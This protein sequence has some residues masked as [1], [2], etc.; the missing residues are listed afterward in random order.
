MSIF[1]GIASITTNL[2]AAVPLLIILLA[3]GK[4]IIK[5]IYKSK[6]L[7]IGVLIPAILALIK[8][9][10]I[11]SEYIFTWRSQ[12]ANLLESLG[13]SLNYLIISWICGPSFI[14]IDPYFV[15]TSIISM[16]KLIF[17]LL[18]FPIFGIGYIANRK[19]LLANTSLIFLII[20]YILH[21]IFGYGLQNGLI[22]TPL[23][24]WAFILIIIYGINY[25]YTKINKKL[26]LT[27]LCGIVI[28]VATL[29]VSWFANFKNT[30]KNQEFEKP[31]GVVR[32]KNILLNKVEFEIVGNSIIKKD[33]GETIISGIDGC[34]VNENSITGN[35]KDTSWFRLYSDKDN[36]YLNI[37]GKITKIEDLFYIFGM[38]IREKYIYKGT[39][40]TQYS[41]NEIILD[42]IKLKD[43]DYKN[44][45]LTVLDEENNEIIIY[46]NEEGIYINKN[47]VIECLDN[48]TKIHIPDFSGH[49]YEKQL[50][51]LFS[52]VMVNI[53]KE[54]PKPNFIAYENVWYRDAAIVAMVLEETGNIEQISNWIKNINEIYDWQNGNN[55]P[56]NLG[57]ILF[58]QSLV[59]TRNEELINKILEE[60]KKLKTEEGY[61][62]GYTDRSKMPV[63]QTKWLIYG[64]KSLGMDYSEYKI[65]EH[66]EDGYEELIWFDKENEEYFEENKELNNPNTNYPYLYYAYLNFNN[67]DI[68]FEKEV[69]PI[70][71]EIKPSKANFKELGKIGNKYA[72]EK[73]VAPHS[74]AAAEMY[75]YLLPLAAQN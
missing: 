24:S 58:L 38:G 43:I 40:L 57:Q 12:E 67:I 64:L 66:L 34:T 55:E 31:Q 22:Y 70:S 69:Y 45:T 59:E 47:E 11:I 33:N 62:I 25:I 16:E 1:F 2:M 39:T 50:R 49:K 44:Y 68:E 13:G 10:P 26:G 61:I 9:Y 27:I 29:N 19:K 53:T 75:L 72:E 41:N 8:I 35:L 52:E 73:I 74:W 20:A 6:L 65:P 5:K 37:S 30:I 21:I 42:N 48:S 18:L 17:L 15:Q 51:I 4:G 71:Y 60:A 28:I 56:D 54:G 3:N 7:L 36:V 32:P 14:N 46:E 23:Y 63:Y